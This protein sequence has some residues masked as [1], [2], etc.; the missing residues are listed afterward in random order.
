MRRL[1]LFGLALAVLF[2]LGI[3]TAGVAQAAF[4]LP[5]ISML[6]DEE[7]PL[8]LHYSSATESLEGEGLEALILC[9]ALTSLCEY[10]AAFT[11]VTNAVEKKACSTPGDAAGTVLVTGNEVHF[12]SYLAS[13]V[14]RVGLLFLVAVFT[15]ECGPLKIKLKGL[16][17]AS[18]NANGESDQTGVDL[19]L[20]GNGKGQPALK[21]YY[22]DEK[23]EVEAKWETNFGSGYGETYV[24]V[25]GEPKL[26]APEGKMFA[27]TLW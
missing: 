17:L 13:G 27:I 10:K 15:I 24:E 8:H 23:E 6:A 22:N 26:Q 9:K 19:V 4:T 25:E 3:A 5:D 1:K 21:K 12:V 2:V 20:A 16:M 7:Y 14:L 18:A 11:H